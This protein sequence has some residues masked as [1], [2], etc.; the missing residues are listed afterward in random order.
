MKKRKCTLVVLALAALCF[1]VTGCSGMVD[2]AQSQPSY[3][4]SEEEIAAAKDIL[5]DDL[6]AMKVSVDGVIYSYPMTV[7]FLLDE[8]WEFPAEALAELDP[9]PANTEY[10]NCEMSRTLGEQEQTM[11]ALVLLNE[12]L[13]DIPVGEAMVTIY[14]IDRSQKHKMILPG[15]ITWTSTI[16][17]VKAAY[18]EP[19]SEGSSG[20]EETF[21]NTILT[22]NYD[23]G[24]VRIG[25]Q[26]KNGETQMT[27]VSFYAE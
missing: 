15:G 1:I 19:T 22:Y 12:S 6:S 5:G 3:F 26:T 10:R 13:E 16:D 4:A 11:D 17:D 14:G 7:Q 21:I 20:S 8:G 27:G 18:G 9:F 23:S 2:M 25:F 24:H